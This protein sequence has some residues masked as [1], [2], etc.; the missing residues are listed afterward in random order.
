MMKASPVHDLDV[1]ERITLKLLQYC[2]ESNWA[3]YDPY[4]GLNSQLFQSLRFLNFK[5]ARLALIQGLKRSPVNLRPLLLVPKTHNAK[6]LALFLS[7]LVKLLRA[8]VIGNENEPNRV[9]D[10]L[11]ELRTRDTPYF[12]WGYSFDWQTRTDLVARRSPNVICTTFAANAL[13]DAYESRGRSQY[14]EAALKAAQFVLERL[15]CSDGEA[16][17]CFN[18]TPL[19]RTQIH[20]ANLLAAALLCRVSNH[21]EE[22]EFLI[23][24][25]KAAQFSA[26]KQND[27]GSWYYGE[28][29][30]P[31]QKWIDNFHTGFNLCAL[32][33]IGRFGHTNEFEPNVIRGL[34]YYRTNFFE[35]DGAPRY[36][37]D[38][39][40]PIDIHSVSQSIITL[41]ALNDLNSDNVNLANKVLCWAIEHMWDKRGYF[42]YQQCRLWKNCIPYLRWGQAW[43]L[44][45]LATFL[46]ATLNGLAMPAT[47]AGAASKE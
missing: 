36:F 38:R 29:N 39:R 25:L 45:A 15:Y 8:R 18:Y 33:S 6:G 44:L 14:C 46:E 35:P 27:D 16:F 41:L 22:R 19:E 3:G 31:S 42:Y 9:A 21:T 7:A 5:W 20:N 24:A 10:L 37:P 32:R 12:S 34:D 4:D 40:Y 13:L 47:T 2:M 23:P 26:G 43:M 11:L 30:Q 28:R 1:V 17:A